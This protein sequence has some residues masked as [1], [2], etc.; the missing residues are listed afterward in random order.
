M[1][2]SD[3]LFWGD[4]YPLKAIMWPPFPCED[5]HLDKTL[6]K[7]VLIKSPLILFWI[8]ILEDIKLEFQK[9]VVNNFKK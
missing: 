1:D 6:W 9:K 5:I 3:F 4:K 7:I 2:C 8:D